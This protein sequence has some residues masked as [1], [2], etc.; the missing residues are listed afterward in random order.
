MN[1]IT[2]GINLESKTI[3]DIGVG[4]GDSSMYLIQNMAEKIVSFEPS[5]GLGG[6]VVVYNKLLENIHRY[7]LEGRIIPKKQDF[8]MN[9]LKS[10]SFDLVFGIN[11]VHHIVEISKGM[12]NLINIDKRIIILLNE[13]LRICKQGGKIVIWEMHSSSIWKYIPLIWRYIDWPLHPQLSTWQK[14]F[15]ETLLRYKITFQPI[16]RFPVTNY[17]LS[18][19]Y[20]N[21]ITNPLF[22][23]IIEK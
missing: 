19:K 22:K 9:S 14:V 18:N 11:S 21:Y 4:E 1:W 17:F 5:E 12:N 15:H 6:S 10:D 8:L 3:C 13:M 16:L 23:V 7:H 2:K 20:A